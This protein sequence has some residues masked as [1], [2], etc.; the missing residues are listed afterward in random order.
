VT[1]YFGDNRFIRLRDIQWISP[2]SLRC[3]Y[4]LENFPGGAIR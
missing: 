1:V 3:K 2:V 4:H